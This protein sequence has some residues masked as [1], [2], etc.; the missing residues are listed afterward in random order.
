[1]NPGPIPYVLCPN[2]KSQVHI[3]K[4]SCGCGY[5]L[6]KKRGRLPGS[7]SGRPVGTTTKAGFTASTGHPTADVDIEMNVPMGRPVGTTAEAGFNVSTG[8]PGH[9]IHDVDV[10][11]NV[12]KGH[13]VGTTAEAGFNV[14]TGHPTADVDIEINVPIGR[15]VHDVD[16]EMNVPIG[17]PVHDVDVEMNVPI[18][19][20]VHDVD[21]EMNVLMGRPVGTTAEAGFNVSTGHPTADV[22]IEINVPI[23][24]PV[25]DV[26]V[27]MNVPMGRPVGTTA[28]AGFNASLGRPNSSSISIGFSIENNCN[29]DTED[30]DLFIEDNLSLLIEHIKQYDLPNAWNTNSLSLNDDLL[31]RAKK[32]I[33]QQVRFDAKPL[34]IGMC[35]CCGSVLWSRVDNSHTRLVN[36]DVHNESIPAVAYQSAMVISNRGYI[37]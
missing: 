9:P 36:L 14:S 19:R 31:V 30:S 21:V 13:P 5:R 15:P 22:D 27:E 11:M 33:G 6:L 24:C 26:D 28:E 34:G 12:P 3:R 23:G 25:H 2:C 32:R 20:P 17:R 16:V 7:S 1:M 8:H 10:E 37:S 35:Y 18:G 29:I 4:I